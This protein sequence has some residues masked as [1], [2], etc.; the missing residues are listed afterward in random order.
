MSSGLLGSVMS[1]RRKDSPMARVADNIVMYISSPWNIA[2]LSSIALGV[3]HAEAAIFCSSKQTP[4][5][6]KCPAL[7]TKV[8]RNSTQRNDF[9]S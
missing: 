8:L 2:I 4:N 7:S 3:T 9:D 1:L 6:N 5:Y